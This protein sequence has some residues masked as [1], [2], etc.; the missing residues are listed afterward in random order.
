MIN[1]FLYRFFLRIRPF[2]A[3][4]IVLLACI[5]GFIWYAQ[6]TRTIIKQ[7]QGEAVTV[8][9]TY[10]ELIRVAIT[11]R[12]NNEEMNVIFEEII[13]KSDIPVIITDTAWTPIM[14]RNITDGPFFNRRE[15][16]DHDTSAQ[17]FEKIKL[18]MAEYEKTYDPKELTISETGT[19]I[20][21]LV[22]GNS[23]LI[24]SLSFMPFIEVGIIA[25]FIF[26]A[27]MGFHNIR[28][29]ER[30]NLWVGLAK[31][32]AHQLGTPISSLMGW[33]EVLRSTDSQD[34]PLEPEE[35]VKQVYTITGTMETDISRLRKVTDRFSQIGSMPDFV[36]C[37][38]NAIV[39][40]AV[41]YFRNRL[42]LLGK[43]IEIS[44]EFGQLPL[45]DANQQLIEW[46]FEN[47]FKNSV[48]AIVRADGRIEITTE[49]DESLNIVRITHG[50]NGKG[51][52]R[53]DQKKIF[54][55][56]YTTKKRGWGLGLTLVK[57]IIE[58][59]HNGRIYLIASQKEKGAVFCVELPVMAKKMGKKK[60]NK[61]RLD[62]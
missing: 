37:D 16:E 43:R 2:L 23:D 58:D 3:R 1:P 31:E 9:Q 39:N 11:E 17:A 15:F 50:D 57:R 27:F 24:H 20:G 52:S 42:P 14:W 44:I 4:Y 61:N 13:R 35:F 28:V 41:A 6:Y 36:P 47:L 12:M 53:E 56:G 49:Y 46:V 60:N 32:T 7:L 18:K 25:V 59:Y 30:S 21:Y 34:E 8:T 51:I 54:V 62:L 33:I 55:P 22:F 5:A 29:T 48:D 45:V 40:D 19:R 38:I 10:A 26:F